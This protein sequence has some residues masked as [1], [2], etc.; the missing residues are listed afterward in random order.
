M[1]LDP[2]T[3]RGLLRHALSFDDAKTLMFDVFDERLKTALFRNRLVGQSQPIDQYHHFASQLCS[4]DLTLF[5]QRSQLFMK[6]LVYHQYK[7]K[8]RRKHEVSISSI[9]LYSSIKHVMR[10]RNLLLFLLVGWVFLQSLTSILDSSRPQK[11]RIRRRPL[12]PKWR[13]PSAS[14]SSSHPLHGYRDNLV[15]VGRHVRSSMMMKAHSPGDMSNKR[16]ENHSGAGVEVVVHNGIHRA[17]RR[18]ILGK[19]LF[20]PTAVTTASKI[21]T[22]RSDWKL[23]SDRRFASSTSSLKWKLH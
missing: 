1:G 23:N 5:L 22:S 13:I 19:Y 21:E 14:S 9:I 2:I 4:A 17:H 11:K 15:K 8:R 7:K 20:N 10:L 12:H 3:R 6:P 16:G 18:P